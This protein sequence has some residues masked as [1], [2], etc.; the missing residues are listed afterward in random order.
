MKP[1][2]PQGK[3][4]FEYSDFM[5]RRLGG[6]V[7]KIA[8]DAGFSCPNRDGAKAVGGCVYCN[9][10]TFN[11]PYC[12]PRKGVTQQLADGKRF[13]ARKYGGSRYLA[14]FQAYS[15]TYAPVERLRRLYA[16]AL[17]CSGVEGVVVATRPDCVTPAV[18]KLLADFARRGA[19]VAVELGIESAHDSTL[20]LI[21]RCHTWADTRRAALMLHDAGIDCGGHLIFGLPDEDVAMMLYTTRCVA[22]LPLS[23][24]KFHQMQV[25]R[26]T[27]LAADF[28][29]WRQH[30]H[31]FTAQSY[32]QLCVEAIRR[33]PPTV[34]LERFV[35]QS[36][37]SLLISPHWGVKPAELNAQI[38]S[39]LTAL[40]A[41]QG[42]KMA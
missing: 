19:Y 16:E 34:A 12:S 38:A 32:A 26:G 40:D 8:I 36:P 2:Q 29:Q 4:Y 25:V 31:Q 30:L 33:L 20:Q 18:A 22:Q 35:S 10:A 6:K 3:R 11:P 21:N 13:F 42:D 17:E 37:P 27:R 9:N 39:L 1:E 15:G 14:Y 7:Q 28:E 5:L 24:L 41:R 23:T